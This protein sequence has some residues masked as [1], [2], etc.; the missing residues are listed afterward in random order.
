MH[1]ENMRKYLPVIGGLTCS[2]SLG[3][4]AL[5]EESCA[6]LEKNQ[7][8]NEGMNTLGK[9]M[10]DEDWDHA[11][12]TAEELFKICEYSP[13][14]NYALGRIWRVKDDNQKTRYYMRRAT[15]HTE[16]FSVNGKI[17]E[18]M[19]FDRYVAENP[20]ANPEAIKARKKELELYQL[21]LDGVKRENADRDIKIEE[22]KLEN[23]KL[24]ARLN[25]SSLNSQYDVDKDRTVYAV[26]MWTGVAG[27]GVGLILAGLGTALLVTE[28]GKELIE[29]PT[30]STNN[31]N[32]SKKKGE[33]KISNKAYAYIG[34]IGAG[35]GL[36]VLGSVVTGIFGYHYTHADGNSD[37]S[38]NLSPVGADFSVSF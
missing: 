37:V 6:D 34:M 27:A 14:L 2:L 25:E 3:T 8:W 5:A 26:G 20:D 28:D 7:V 35:I 22:L 38:L 4:A 33:G 13:V 17:L 1:F 31:N 16:D 30:F 36:T 19:W 23:T 15:L 12:K 9:Q 11:L 32:D 21:A 18:Q 24:Q 10:A 29:W